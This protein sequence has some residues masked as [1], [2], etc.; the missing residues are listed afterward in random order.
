MCTTLNDKD[1]ID[2][3]VVSDEQENKMDALGLDDNEK[4]LV[5]QGLASEDDFNED[6]D[7]MEDDDYYG[8]D[9]L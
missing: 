4:E 6:P 5:R 7:E 9:D 8:E 2:Y 3:M 1:V